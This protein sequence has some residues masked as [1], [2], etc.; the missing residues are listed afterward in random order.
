MVPFL[1]GS[2]SKLFSSRWVKCF[3][4]LIVAVGCYEGIMLWKDR[5]DGFSIDRI[6]TKLANAPEWEIPTSAEKLAQVNQILAQPFCYLGHGFQFYAFESID[7]KYVLKFFRHQRLHPPVLYDWLPDWGVVRDIKAKKSL[8]RSERV[9]LLFESLK[10][11][12]DNIPEE[13]GLIYVHLN[14]T[15]NQHPVALLI[16]KLEDEYKMPLD[17]TEFVLQ[18][19]ATYVKPTIKALMK[20]ERV[21]DAKDRITQLFALLKKT[22]KKGIIDTDGALIY[23]NNVGFTEDRAVYIDI[24]S[25]VFKESIKTK[26]RFAY[27]LNRL[28]PLNKWLAANYPTLSAHFERQQKKT[29]DSFDEEV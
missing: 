17:D 10:I 29:I 24:G 6:H 28:K 27:D 23:K 9:K 7:G 15:K 8:K 2:R 12:Y 26:E 22:A 18:Y 1:R 14:K 19:K 25:F 11:A 13:S 4:V 20:A 21:A 3:I 16:D 5:N